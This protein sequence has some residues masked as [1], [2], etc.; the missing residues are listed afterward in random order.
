M[1]TK[2]IKIKLKQLI[3]KKESNLHE[4]FQMNFNN[5]A[6]GESAILNIGF[7]KIYLIFRLTLFARH[8]GDKYLFCDDTKTK[9]FLNQIKIY[10]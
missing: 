1:L 7:I 5:R 3:S 4:I 9:I 6:F 8:Q 2:S 10:N